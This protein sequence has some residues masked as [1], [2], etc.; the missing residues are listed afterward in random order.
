VQL[1]PTSIAAGIADDRS[2]HRRDRRSGRHP[3]TVNLQRL[4]DAGAAVAVLGA[5]H[6]DG[7]NGDAVAGDHVYT[8]DVQFTESGAGAAARVGGLQGP[9]EAAVLGRN[10]AQHQSPAGGRCRARPRRRRRHRRRSRRPP[11]QRSG[12]RPPGVSVDARGTA[13]RQQSANSSASTARGRCSSPIMPATT[14]S[15]WSSTTARSTARRPS[16]ASTPAQPMPADRRCRSPTRTFPPARRYARR[17]GSRDPEGAPIGYAWELVDKPASSTPR[18]TTRLGDTRLRRRP[19]RPLRAAPDGD[20]RQRQPEFAGRDRRHRVCGNTPPTAAPGPDQSVAPGSRVDLDGSASF[21]PDPGDG[22]AQYAWSFIAVPHGSTAALSP[23]IQVF[24][25][26]PLTSFVADLAGDY[27]IELVVTDQRGARSAPRRVLVQAGSPDGAQAGADP[28]V[29][30]TAVAGSG[31]LVLAVEGLRF[32]PAASVVFGTTLLATRFISATKLPPTCRRAA[33]F[34]RFFP[35]AGAQPGVRR[36]RFQQSSVYRRAGDADP[37]RRH[38]LGAGSRQGGNARSRR[39]Q[40]HAGVEGAL[41][42]Q[43]CWRRPSAAR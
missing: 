22:I 29:P 28:L 2:R 33:R 35:R 42:R 24:P 31:P 9:V 20:R 40:L 39:R 25:S 11:Q 21:D 4:N 17:A 18:S 34:A 26:P 27:V 14:S 37:E 6:D 7:A 19:G 3:S 38:A 43:Q 15:S 8:L 36:R 23:A 16:F 10:A 41:R 1:T 5:L 30:D 12:R 32:D 13:G